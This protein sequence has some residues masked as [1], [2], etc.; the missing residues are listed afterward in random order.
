LSVTEVETLVRDPYAIFARHVLRLDALPPLDLAPGAA[1]RGTLIHDIFGGFAEAHPHAMPAHA[2]EEILGRGSDAFRPIE[3]AYPELHAEWWPRFERLAAAYVVWEEARRRDI[4]EVHPE[5]TGS[6][7]IPAPEGETFRLRARA[8]RI[9]ANRDGTFAIVDFKTGAPPGVKEVFAGFSPQ[10]TL[11]AA[12]L[13]RGAFRDLPRSIETP[14]ILYVHMSG[15]RTPLDCREIKTPKGE[16]RTVAEVVVE[17]VA[18]LE[19]L[20]A[21]YMR[22]E[23]AYLSR[24]YPKYARRYS[25]YDHLARVKEWSLASGVEEDGA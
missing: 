5:I 14:R 12:M 22:G 8:D 7:S 25:D 20:V 19:R 16:S 3:E 1:D 4:R 17:H 24:P 13:M 2:L 10:L 6:L 11:E 15:G 9:E 18:K 21:A 23:A